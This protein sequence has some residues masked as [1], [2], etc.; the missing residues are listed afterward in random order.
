MSG[1]FSPCT[2]RGCVTSIPKLEALTVHLGDDHRGVMA[3]LNIAK[4]INDMNSLTQSIRV[5]HLTL[6]FKHLTFAN[7]AQMLD[8]IAVLS[9]FMVEDRL[10]ITGYDYHL[11]EWQRA[12]VTLLKMR[13]QPMSYEMEGRD[14]D[15]QPKPFHAEYVVAECANDFDVPGDID[16]PLSLY[17]QHINTSQNNPFAEFDIV[18]VDQRYQVQSNIGLLTR[19]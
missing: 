7:H 4:F 8:F 9:A 1:F 19:K 5:K 10:T 18:Y 3:Q 13:S 17:E 15:D 12:M 2:V 11:A 6:N 16:D 14:V